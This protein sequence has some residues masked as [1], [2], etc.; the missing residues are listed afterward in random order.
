MIGG[1]LSIFIPKGV[2]KSSFVCLVPVLA[3]IALLNGTW[4]EGFK[5]QFLDLELNFMRVDRIIPI[6]MC[7]MTMYSLN[8]ISTSKGKKIYIFIILI[9]IFFQQISITA[10]KFHASIRANLKEDVFIE[11]KKNKKETKIF[12][13]IS[14]ILDKNNY[15]NKRFNLGNDKYSW[16][17]YFHYDSYNIIKDIV[18]ICEIIILWLPNSSIA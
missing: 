8:R 9:S 1:L 15:K 12:S 4:D 11:L 2:I 14:I 18:K 16:D 13:I 17:N 10:K 7:L 6:L 3:L 5:V